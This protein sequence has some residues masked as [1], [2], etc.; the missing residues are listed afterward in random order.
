MFF[1]YSPGQRFAG[2][3]GSS[4]RSC[5][6]R[7]CSYHD[8]GNDVKKIHPCLWAGSPMVWS[9]HHHICSA[10]V[11]SAVCITRQSALLTGVCTAQ[12]LKGHPSDRLGAVFHSCFT[13]AGLSSCISAPTGKT[14]AWGLHKNGMHS[15]AKEMLLFSVLLILTEKAGLLAHKGTHKWCTLVNYSSVHF[16]FS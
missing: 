1:Y 2:S 14:N 8:S 4:S 10:Q 3:L 16:P 5:V 7:S 9:H 12:A 15:T 13:A 11:L 6:A